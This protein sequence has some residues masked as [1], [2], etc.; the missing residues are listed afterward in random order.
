[1]GATAELDR[2]AGLEDAHHVAVLVAE[3]RQ[4]T[5]R[6]GLLL[7][8]LEGPDRGVGERLGVGDLLDLGD[9]CVGDGLVVREVEPQPVGSDQRP[10]LL[11]VVA[12]H[13]P[14][15]VVDEVGAGVV[16]PDRVAPGDIDA[17]RRDLTRRDRAVD[18]AGDVTA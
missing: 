13:R 2:P 18:D 17:G 14:Q 5:E 12:E 10:G 1:M 6:L 8:G 3:E 16:S 9:L 11:D 7:G 15:G 4:R